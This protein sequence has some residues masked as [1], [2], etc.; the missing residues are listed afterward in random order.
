MTQ[1]GLSR[2]EE[3]A[4]SRLLAQMKRKLKAL[5]I[6][7][8]IDESLLRYRIGEAVWEKLPCYVGWIHSRIKMDGTVQPCGPCTL[9][10]GDFNKS[11]F[12]DIWNGRPYKDFRRTA[13]M[14]GQSVKDNLTYPFELF[15]IIK[16]HEVDHPPYGSQGHQFRDFAES[17][18][19]LFYVTLLIFS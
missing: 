11:T 7:H 17:T 19:G 4:L 3:K 18:G 8:N 12:Q 2:S 9:K 16:R 6:Q 10:M 15:I 5:S 13:V 1:H 14:A